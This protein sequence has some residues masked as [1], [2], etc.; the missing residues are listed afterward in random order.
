[1]ELSLSGIAINLI[2]VVLTYYSLAFLYHKI[3]KKRTKQQLKDKTLMVVFGSGGHTTEM[4][5]MLE[6]LKVE[7]Y[8]KVVFVV[9]HSDQW[10]LKKLNSFLGESQLK[11]V[12]LLKLF[13]AREVKQSYFSSIWTTLIGLMHSV[14]IILQNRPDLIVTNGPG[15]AVPLCYASFLLQK[16]LLIKPSGKLLYIESFCRVKTLSL[17][18]KL[19]KPIVDK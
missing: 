16:C 5:L 4:L 1:M 14:K 7:K 15:T 8:G 11:Q 19:L 10:S 3:L 2:Y 12:T 17:S 18:G 9:G 6:G 13:R